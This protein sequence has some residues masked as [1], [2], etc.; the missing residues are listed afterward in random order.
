LEA[1][2]LEAMP[3]E[4]MP[5]EAI[6]LEAVL[7]SCIRAPLPRA[8]GPDAGPVARARRA[9]VRGV[10][11]RRGYS[12]V[13]SLLSAFGIAFC[14]ARSLTFFFARG[15]CSLLFF[16]LSPG[17]GK[18]RP[19]L[20][21]RPCVHD[22][23]QRNRGT[24]AARCG[25]ARRDRQ[26]DTGVHS[27]EM[28]ERATTP[29]SN[30]GLVL[31]GGSA[32]AAYEV[33]VVRY[34]VEEVARALGRPVPIDVISG[35]SAGSIN[36]VML[37]AFAGEPTRGAMLAAQWTNLAME[38]V[39]R[40][41][42]AEMLAMGRRLFGRGPPKILGFTRGGGIFD[43]SGIERIVRAAV[44]FPSI[45]EH[46]RHGR[47]EALS[48]STTHVASG[49]TVVFVQ[50]RDGRV[51]SWTAD[52]TM[53]PRPTTIRAE[54]ALASAAVPLLFPAVDID[55]Q[56]YCDGGLRQNVPLSPARRLGAD[57]LIVVN[58]RY[59]RE[60]TPTVAVADARE[61]TF[62]DPLFIVGK[63]MNALLLD[64]IENDI[65]RLDKLNAVLMAGTRR[66]G[67]GFANALNEELGRSGEGA[68]RPLDV[69]YIRASQDIGVLAGE[70]V[71]S[72][73]FAKRNRGLLGRMLR[74][75]AEG[76]YEADMLS[77]ILFDGPFAGRLIEIGRSDAR[78]RH[79]ELVRFFAKRL[80]C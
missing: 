69:V 76:E 26:G 5:L 75:V 68:L 54:H 43:P 12:R 22:S 53:V 23:G 47:L 4:A 77:Y 9:A 79:D 80:A 74:R 46:M 33:G 73:E 24:F 78:A 67:D 65:R 38:Q 58:P 28:S 55:G 2:P 32:R 25:V 11:D 71:R 8:E 35:T 10:V 57:G 59:I 64:R 16:V 51:P 36:A 63:A 56:F 44:P 41:S 42:P 30:V 31:A 19:K 40:P 39:V 14:I 20:V 34:I 62:P 17:E 21:R 60:E 13:D 61:I 6:P 15:M 45:A 7:R 18:Q 66:F 29:R 1:T 3:L 52:P 27:R 50:R 72:P 48:I 49:R 70:Y 37:A